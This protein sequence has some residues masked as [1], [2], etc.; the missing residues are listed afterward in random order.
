[1]FYNKWLKKNLI[2]G[3]AV[4]FGG[5][6]INGCG[7][8]GVTSEALAKKLCAYCMNDKNLNI[9][10]NTLNIEDASLFLENFKKFVKFTELCKTDDE[11]N[12][13]KLEMIDEN[14]QKAIKAFISENGDKLAENTFM[15]KMFAVIKCIEEYKLT[16][17]LYNKIV[18]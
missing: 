12:S 10:N 18:K 14:T 15:K 16:L 8:C 7:K 1:M 13:Y 3:S 5:N 6:L 11:G 17:A 2:L 9:S 4:I